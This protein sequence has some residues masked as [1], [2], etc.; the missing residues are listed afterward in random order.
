MRNKRRMFAI[1]MLFTVSTAF[2]GCGRK[3]PASPEKASAVVGSLAIDYTSRFDV[4]AVTADIVARIEAVREQEAQAAADNALEAAFTIP[5]LRAKGQK[6]S[7]FIPEGWELID[8][9]TLDFNKDGLTDYVG[10]LQAVWREELQDSYWQYP[11]ILFAVASDRDGQYD[12]SF[13]DA[14]LIRTGEE[15]GAFG[16]PYLP[17]TAEGT[18]FT[19]SSYGGSA[20]RWG[21]EYTYTY[22][23]G[24]WYLTQS[25][26][27]YGYGSYITSYE[28]DNWETGVGIRERRSDEFDDMEAHWED[29][30]P[31]YDIVY[32]L[33]LDEMPTLSQAGM[34]W[35]LATDRVTDWKV[36]SIV[37]AEGVTLPEDMVK[38]PQEVAWFDYNDE[39]CL[40]YTFGN[41]SKEK[42]WLAMYRPQDRELSII[43]ETDAGA[44]MGD[45]EY[46][47]EKIYYT[48]KVMGNITYR[49]TKD[50]VETINR[51][52]DIIGIVLHRMNADGT[53]KETLFEYWYPGAEQEIMDYEVPYLSLVYEISGG[54]IVAE[55]YVGYG[56]PHPFYR[57]NID[58]SGLRQ[59][60]QVPKAAN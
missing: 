52:E 24:T 44:A 46:Y 31:E 60:G 25:E 20:W 22:K 38:L 55:V 51:K 17:L 43:M 4:R 14:N 19:T 7:D 21:E 35:W 2:S 42:I 1:M 48:T 53:G 23:D 54:E 26:T 34:R 41:E 37:F 12:L 56:E 16:D 15:G 39:D 6:L 45:L 59:I 29:D 18:S 49:T 50:G 47:R 8:N 27:F 30:E 13:Q 10:V 32:E 28:E 40:L 58:G 5:E 57:M 3:A 9:V 11:R 33:S 36:D